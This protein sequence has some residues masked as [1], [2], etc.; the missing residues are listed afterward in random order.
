MLSAND[1]TSDVAIYFGGGFKTHQSP[2]PLHLAPCRRFRDSFGSAFLSLFSRQPR[3]RALL[4]FGA[5]PLGVKNVEERLPITGP[6]RASTEVR[7][8][9]GRRGSDQE[10]GRRI[11]CRRLSRHAGAPRAGT[12]VRSFSFGHR[13]GFE[14]PRVSNGPIRS[15]APGDSQTASGSPSNSRS[16]RGGVADGFL[17][18]ILPGS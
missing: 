10:G 14:P 8:V 1:I 3:G 17:V 4:W 13:R 18:E 12:V 15:V 7:R 16:R 6:G 11:C 5:Q 2:P 9:G